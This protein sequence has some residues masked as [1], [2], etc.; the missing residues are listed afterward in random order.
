MQ[1]QLVQRPGMKAM[2]ESVDC[3][4]KTLALLGNRTVA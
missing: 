3:K 1:E 4:V 2:S